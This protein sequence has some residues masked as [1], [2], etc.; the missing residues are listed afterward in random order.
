MRDVYVLGIGQTIFGKHGSLT[1]NDLGAAF[2]LVAVKDVEIS[3]FA[4]ACPLA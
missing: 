4:S 1:I 3:L 2:S